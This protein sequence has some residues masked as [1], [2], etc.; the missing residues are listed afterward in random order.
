MLLVPSLVANT[1]W[2]LSRFNGTTNRKTILVPYSRCLAIDIFGYLISL[3][4]QPNKIYVNRYDRTNLM[5]IKQVEL[6]VPYTVV[7][8]LTYYDRMIFIS[9]ENNRIYIFD[10]LNFTL[11]R[12]ITCG[13][14]LDQP[15]NLIFMESLKLMIVGSYD[16]NKLTF[17]RVN[18]LTNYTCLNN[19]VSDGK[20][21]ALFKVNDTFFY[22]TT[23]ATYVIYSYQFDG[24]IWIRSVYVN[25]SQTL[26]LA[27]IS[28]AHIKIDSYQRRW[29]L[30]QK[31]GIVLYDQWGTYLGKWNMGKQP[32][33]LIILNDYR[34][35]VGENNNSSFL[36]L[37]DPQIVS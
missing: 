11:L 7:P 22:L 19:T 32:F 24:Q 3:E 13:T 4:I 29:V 26:Q 2:L 18:S 9:G 14:N 31:F 6:P 20:L 21:Q 10:D 16:N 34:I 5:L 36:T 37:Y 15:R 28:V 23:I 33:D 25:V 27:G 1:N 35:I 17:F 12:Q 8:M 30:V